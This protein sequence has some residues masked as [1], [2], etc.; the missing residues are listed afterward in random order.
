MIALRLL[1]FNLIKFTD[2][3]NKF[4]QWIIFCQPLIF[5]TI[6]YFMLKVNPAINIDKYIFAVGIISAWS[7]IL[8]A[9]GTAL[10]SEKWGGTFE[11]ILGSNTSLFR[12]VL[13]KSVCNSLIGLLNICLTILY[14]QIIYGFEIHT[15]N[16]I[17]SISS[18]I[19]LIYSLISLGMVLAVLCS[20]FNNVFEYQN[21]MVFPFLI[22]S[23]LFIPVNDLPLIFQPISYVIPMT[24]SIK[25]LYDS[26]IGIEF[27]YFYLL[28]GILISSFY[29]VLTYIFISKIELIFR[30]TNKIGVF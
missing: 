24:W 2:L 4:Y 29:F 9:S 25:S 7:F 1:F 3:R 5:L 26:L 6:L 18:L 22:L 19:V 11:L 10:I 12:I 15:S 27:S 17:L 14:A 23:G 20:L 8:Y 21:L 16:L 13:T 28:G 30:K